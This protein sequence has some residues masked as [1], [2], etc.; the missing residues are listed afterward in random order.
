MALAK[1]TILFLATNMAIIAT[2][3]ILMRI[4]GLDKM[5][6]G[7]HMSMLIMCA[8]WGMGAS[9]V[10]LFMS[11]MMVKRSMGVQLIDENTLD[12]GLKE[13]RQTVYDLAAKA[14]LPKMPE[15]G[16]YQ[17]RDVNAFATGPSK[18]NFLVAVS[19]GLLEKMN[20]DEV[21]G[22]LGHEIA[23]IANGDMVTMTLLQGVINAFVMY[24]ARV[25]A[26]GVSNAS[27]GNS[28]GGF[29]GGGMAYFGIMMVFQYVFGMAGSMIVGAF[30][31]HREY[32]ADKGGAELAGQDKMVAA[33]QKLQQS[34]GS[35]VSKPSPVASMQ[36]SSKSF[37]KLMST[38]P[39]LEKR[40]E[41]LKVGQL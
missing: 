25:V 5:M 20:K 1:R 2:I 13:I 31:R 3:S 38:H 11:K 8:V 28:E 37:M 29:S 9:I 14:G 41:A 12:E 26:F 21:E 34:F 23:H 17:S 4:F 32:R 35:A 15:V 7:G 22:V 39:P 18:S 30:S 27:R 24:L 40:I 6:S 16:Y 33:L 19:T 36:I 10:S